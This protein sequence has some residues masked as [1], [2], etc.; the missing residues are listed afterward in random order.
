MG[1]FFTAMHI[2]SNSKDRFVKTFT[3][4]MKKDGYAPCAEDEATVVL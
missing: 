4:L 1:K 3:E 2:K